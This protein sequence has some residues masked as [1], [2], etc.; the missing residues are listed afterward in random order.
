MAALRERSLADVLHD[1]VA[2]IQDI[3]RSELRLASVEIRQE[4]AKAA[5]AGKVAAAGGV[6]ALF[7]FALLL[8]AAVYA[9]ALV[10]PPWLAALTVGIVLAIAGSILIS[11]GSKRLKLIHLKPEKTVASIRETLHG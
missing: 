10:M 5:S 3:V 1:I 6:L 8:L 2:N 11:A 4:L 9:L 7:A